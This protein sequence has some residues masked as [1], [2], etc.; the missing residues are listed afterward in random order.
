MN[1]PQ[2][3]SAALAHFDTWAELAHDQRSEWLAQ[4]ATQ[5]PLAHTQLLKLIEADSNATARSFMRPPAAMATPAGKQFGPWRIERLIGTGGMAQVWLAQRTDEL[6]TGLAAIKLMRLAFADAGANERFAREGKMLGRLS[7]PHI[8]RLLDAGV[9]GDGERYLVLEYV[10]GEPIDSWCNRHSLTLAERMKLFIV[11]CNAVAHAHENLIVHRDLKPSNIFVTTDGEVKLL[12]FGIAKL[13]TDDTQSFAAQTGLTRDMG[14]VLTPAYAAP[15]QLTGGAI[16]TATDVYGLGVVL[17]EL[18]NGARPDQLPNSGDVSQPLWSLPASRS[19]ISQVADQRRTTVNALRKALRGDAAIVV[20]KAIKGVST[21]RYRSASEFAADLQRVLDRRPI[22]ARPDS[23]LYR[24][25]KYVQRHTI[26]V[27]MSALI[28]ISV[29]AGVTGTVINER[30]AHSEA[31]RATAVK[32]FLLD[33][34]EQARGSVRGGV[35]AREATVNDMLIAGA[36]RVD[37]AFSAQPA[38]RDEVFQILVEL[39]SD[40]G[41]REQITNLARRRVAAAESGFGKGSVHTA[42]AKVML[43][44]VLMNFGEFDEAKTLLGNAEKLLDDAGDNDSIERARLLRWQGTW[45]LMTGTKQPW[46]DH[47]LRRATQLLRARYADD[48]E[49]LSALATLSGVACQNGFGVEAMNA[50]DELYQRTRVRY[51]A[52]NLYVA[53]AGYSRGQLL[54][55]RDRA[56][57]AVPLLEQSIVG[58]RKYVG[59]NSPNVVV[60]QLT[61]AKA[62]QA[63]GDT[64]KSQQALT[65]AQQSIQHDHSGDARLMQEF[66]T[67]SDKIEKLKSG[68]HLHCG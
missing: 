17:Y 6:Y 8:A 45:D 37:H 56:G 50:A 40:T 3:L 58:F 68:I 49:L 36:D 42:P 23:G 61:L 33:L 2:I 41:D 63:A 55:L 66:K 25:R 62:Y 54:V 13:L 21:E 38:I 10:D 18:L 32:H 27:A 16:S 59:E 48:D 65:A 14:T 67:V 35:T 24:A 30:R 39:Y 12:D 20:G 60:A 51:G 5:E 26:G 47:P 34:F 9:N 53:I 64:L 1:E 52:D 46:P 15:E 19:D 7:D 11:V 31:Q 57:E 22:H 28:A 43:A 44:G 4:L 29:V